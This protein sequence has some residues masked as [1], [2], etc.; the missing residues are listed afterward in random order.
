VY[1]GESNFYSKDVRIWGYGYPGTSSFNGPLYV[2]SSSNGSTAFRL[3]TRSNVS[4]FPVA[5]F[6]PVATDTVIAFDV[7]PH[8]SPTEQA[9]NGFAWMDVCDGDFNADAN[10]ASTCARAG[11]RSGYV[12]FSSRSFNGGTVKPIVFNL[13]QAG[14]GLFEAMRITSTGT[15]GIGTT[16]PSSLLHL[17][18]T[19]N[20]VLTI[21]GGVASAA[22]IDFKQAGTSYGIVDFDGNNFNVGNLYVNG[23]TILKA[24]NAER[25]RIT[26]SGNVGIGTTSPQALLGLQGAVGVNN[27]QMYLFAD[28]RVAFNGTALNSGEAMRWTGQ[29]GGAANTIFDFCDNASGNRCVSLDPGVTSGVADIYSSWISGSEPKLHLA[30]YSNRATTAGITID[31]TGN[32][33][34]GTTSPMASLSVAGTGS[35]GVNIGGFFGSGYGAI[36]LNATADATNYHFLAGNTVTDN[37]LYINRTSGGAIQFRENGG[38]TPQ[39]IIASGGN[40]GIGTTTPTAQLHTTGTVRFSNF[41][42][43]TLTTDASGN[44]SVSSDERLKNVDG[45]FT[46]GLSA[47]L[48]LSP[49]SYHWN[50]TSELDQTTQYAGFSAQNVQQAIPEAVGENPNGYLSLNDR[51]VLAA[52]VNAVKE[53]WNAMQDRFASQDARIATLEARIAELEAR[54]V[55]NPDGSYTITAASQTATPQHVIHNQ[56]TTNNDTD[57]EPAT[58]TPPGTA[59]PSTA[60]S[61]QD[62]GTAPS[63]TQTTAQPPADFSMQTTA[64][65]SNPFNEQPAPAESVSST[66]Q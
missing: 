6:S 58:S 2:D 35:S 60:P 61:T 23:A 29:A 36:S 41:G 47:V 37:T 4:T 8:G 66:S 44:V 16:S 34:I 19:G 32:V 27:K 11:V 51:P 31:T 22:R 33:G 14:S 52:V 55:V 50:A 42:A 15:I 49:I 65:E 9:N 17:E 3:Q 45:D 25:M 7:L 43:G 24:G 54:P 28:G 48:K 57:S 39:M 1:D 56:Q 21:N 53:L 13:G 5:N 30:T 46:R 40:I 20:T 38:A 18:S 63:E 12:E 64:P 62:Q 59:E 10:V 26:S